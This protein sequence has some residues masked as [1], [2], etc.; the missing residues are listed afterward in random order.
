[1]SRAAGGDHRG[2]DTCRG[3]L[4]WGTGRTAHLLGNRWGAT[5]QKVNDDAK[6]IDDFFKG[7]GGEK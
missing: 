4:A 1:M 6:Q 5:R 3:E 7:G 2:R